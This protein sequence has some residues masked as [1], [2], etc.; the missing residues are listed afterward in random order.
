MSSIPFPDFYLRGGIGCG[1]FL[2]VSGIFQKRFS[3]PMGIPLFAFP[4]RAL[5]SAKKECSNGH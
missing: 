4:D 1:G 5:L 3:R 2:Q